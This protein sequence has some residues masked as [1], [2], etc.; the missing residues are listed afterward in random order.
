MRCI[1]WC[2]AERSP[3]RRLLTD[4]VSPS[5]ADAACIDPAWYGGLIDQRPKV[6]AE[7]IPEEFVDEI[8]ICAGTKEQI[9]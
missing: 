7:T 4:S 9:A 3:G 2:D 5:Q 8:V 6:I 1:A